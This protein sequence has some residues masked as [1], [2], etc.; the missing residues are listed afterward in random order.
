MR[1]RGGCINRK[2]NNREL[3]KDTRKRR[4]EK[5]AMIELGEYIL[6]YRKSSFLLERAF[7]LELDDC[8]GITWPTDSLPVILIRK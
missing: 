2:L 8:I 4:R 1:E 6:L 7:V 3:L 5:V